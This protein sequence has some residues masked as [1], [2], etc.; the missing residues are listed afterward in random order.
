MLSEGAVI[1]RE[2]AG[3]SILQIFPALLTVMTPVGEARAAP[4]TGVRTIVF[5][6]VIMDDGAG[7]PLYNQLLADPRFQLYPETL[8]IED[9]F[10][11][12]VI[13]AVEP[14]E[15]E[16]GDALIDKDEAARETNICTGIW[17]FTGVIWAKLEL[18]TQTFFGRIRILVLFPPVKSEVM[19][20]SL[21]P[22]IHEVPFDV[23]LPSFQLAGSRYS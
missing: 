7:L 10:I 6:L 16:L 17:L 18:E 22:C 20:T 1:E 5:V 2:V 15:M 4:Q 3:T 19:V 12:K 23:L 14:H 11:V 21:L 8:G 9:E 13:G